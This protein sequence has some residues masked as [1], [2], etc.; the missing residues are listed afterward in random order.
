MVISKNMLRSVG[1]I[2][3]VLAVT[4]LSVGNFIKTEASRSK[5]AIKANV[6][7][8]STGN[9][10]SMI[11]DL[12]P[13]PVANIF[14]DGQKIDLPANGSVVIPAADGSQTTVSRD[15]S[16]NPDSDTTV[17][18]KES[19]S[20][21]VSVSVTTDDS[22]KN[23]T[24]SGFTNFQSSSFGQSSGTNSSFIYSTSGADI[25]TSH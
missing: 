8:L 16:T 3:S 21:S 12:A 2:A 15:S 20:N 10:S 18:K 25:T 4:G 1:T 17:M 9:A 19:P 23:T 7:L 14:V 24:T 5:Q 22:S 13:D 6:Q 11:S